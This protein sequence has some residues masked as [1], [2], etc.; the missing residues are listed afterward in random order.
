MIRQ[1]C[2]S[3]WSALEGDRHNIIADRHNVFALSLNKLLM[4]R[5]TKGLNIHVNKPIKMWS[6][7]HGREKRNDNCPTTYHLSL[8][9]ENFFFLIVIK[10]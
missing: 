5:M 6:G 4:D 1:Y 7:I 2:L 10:V 8:I 3:P 9:G